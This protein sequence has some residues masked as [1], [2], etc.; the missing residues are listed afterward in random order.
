LGWA[1]LGGGATVCDEAS[2]GGWRQ[3]HLMYSWCWKKAGRHLLMM[4]MMIFSHL[5]STRPCQQANRGVKCQ[6][7]A[8]RH[9]PS[10]YPTLVGLT[11]EQNRGA[12]QQA[13]SA[14]QDCPKR[15]PFPQAPSPSS[16]GQT[17]WLSRPWTGIYQSAALCL[18]ELLPAVPACAMNDTAG[19]WLNNACCGLLA[20]FTPCDRRPKCPTR[21]GR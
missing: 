17:S 16:R 7:L 3:H 5:Q 11:I 9:H 14:K 10:S 13:T 6:S 2:G 18:C 12:S 8:P 20:S 1:G 15:L 4:M 19:V 21:G